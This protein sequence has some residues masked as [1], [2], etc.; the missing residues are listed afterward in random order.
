MYDLLFLCFKSKL[1]LI[2][3]YA[4]EI[5][6]V[7]EIDQSIGAGLLSEMFS[8]SCSSYSENHNLKETVERFNIE[9]YRNLFSS[10]YLYFIS[11]YNTFFSIN[12]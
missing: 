1:Q 4:S 10:L 5:N 11:F 2:N 8:I 3:A 7:N 6:G 12:F 9:V